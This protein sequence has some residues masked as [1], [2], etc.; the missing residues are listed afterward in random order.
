MNI[1]HIWFDVAGT[2]YR[3]T[4]D[5]N[6]AHDQHRYQTYATL[7]GISDIKLAKAEFEQLYKIHGSNSAVFTSLGQPSDY[8][9]KAFEELDISNLLHPDPEVINTLTNLRSKVPISVFTNLKADKIKSL[10]KQLAIPLEL[11]THVLS[12]DDVSQRKPALEGF[13][14]MVETSGMP[15]SQNLYI[16]DRVDVDIKPAKTVGMQTGL[17]YDD[18]PEADYT[19]DSFDQIYS[20]LKG[21]L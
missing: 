15:A 13:K 12:G 1:G 2:L 20:I 6:I 17:I 21:N 16:G 19:F 5:F 10:F 9:M 11:F 8:W 3:E 14:L 7:M 4:P 18:S